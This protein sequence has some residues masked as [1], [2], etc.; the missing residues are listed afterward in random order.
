MVAGNLKGA[1]EVGESALG[2]FEA[3]GN[4]WWACRTLWG[5]GGATNLAGHWRE[6]LEYC[7]RALEHGQAVDDLR[8]KAVG[9]WRTALTDVERGDVE[10]GLRCCEEAL[11]LS[12]IPF[13]L[14]M[15]RAVRGYGRVKAG[16]TAGGMAELREALEWLE[17]SHLRYQRAR[18]ALWLADGH[19][20]AGE[21]S[22]ARGVI[23]EVLGI[24]RDF[25]Y[26]R[27]EGEAER[28]LSESLIAEDP[29][30]AA[31]HLA[32]A[33]RILEE[34]G[35]RNELAKAL[36]ARGG[37]RRAAGDVVSARKLLESALAT[38][39]ELGTLD[40]PPRVR[41]ELAVFAD[42]PTS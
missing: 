42:T 23:E 20:R 18:F 21:P 3:R 1:V 2:V 7:R 37:L 4:V 24:S 12:P 34:V 25:G 15:T 40:E 6:S 39:E 19:L 11:A 9:W 17:R 35:A 5:L 8:L 31:D 38:F 36:A 30:G 27:V 28:L 33:E 41:A 26:R 10:G 29:T 16:N 14:A 32:T 22:R 13:D